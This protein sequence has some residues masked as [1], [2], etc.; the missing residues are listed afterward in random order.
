MFNVSW[1][2]RHA[3]SLNVTFQTGIHLL[4]SDSENN[5]MRWSPWQS[6]CFFFL[7]FSVWSSERCNKGTPDNHICVRSCE[8]E[9]QAIDKSGMWTPL[10]GRLDV[11]AFPRLKSQLLVHRWNPSPS[12]HQFTLD[13][14]LLKR[15]HITAGEKLSEGFRF[16]LCSCR[17][18]PA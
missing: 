10:V 13:W 6:A 7:F 18:F 12:S 11:K 15:I 3:Q 2:Y 8:P 14:L 16:Y 4:L 1:H 17:V 5:W 9:S